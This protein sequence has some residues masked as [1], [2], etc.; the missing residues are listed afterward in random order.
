[1][2][3]HSVT[4]HPTQ[5]NAPRLTPAVQ[6]GTRFTYPGGMEGWVDIVDLIAPR[7]GVEPATFR[8]RVQRSTA[9]PPRQLAPPR[10]HKRIVGIGMMML[11]VRPTE[12]LSIVAKRYILTKVSKQVNRKCP[13]RNIKVQLSTSTSTLSP[14]SPD[15]QNFQRSTI[16]YLNSSWRIL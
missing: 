13:P 8:S 3:S 9:A 6:A 7:P 4:C 11:S 14:I 10:L 15:L 12:T 1:M 16:G 2:G 5:V